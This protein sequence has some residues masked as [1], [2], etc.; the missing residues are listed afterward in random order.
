MMAE[1]VVA[2]ISRL[3]AMIPAKGGGGIGAIRAV[4][5]FEWRCGDGNTA[6]IRVLYDDACRLF[7]LAHA[8]NRGVRVRYVV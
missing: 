5:R 3:K 6:G 8:F 1:A 2:S 4:I 7:E